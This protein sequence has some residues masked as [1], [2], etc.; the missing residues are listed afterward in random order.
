MPKLKKIARSVLLI[1]VS[2]IVGVNIYL[3]NARSLMGNALPMPFGYGT[4]VVL[5]GSMEPTIMVDDLIFVREQD[6]Y[7][8]DDIVVYQSGTVPV[9]HRIVEI[10]DESVTTRGD[11]NN[12]DDESIPVEAIKGEVVAAIPW[13]GYGVWALKSPV[14]VI[15]MLAAAVFLIEA[16]FRTGKAEKEAEKEKLKEEIRALLKELEEK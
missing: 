15:V 5:T 9:V 3:W 1:F 11:A 2:L 12:V 7:A 13:L 10:S 14:A 4:A 6:S 8:L 16:S